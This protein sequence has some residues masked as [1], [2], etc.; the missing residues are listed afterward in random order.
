MKL[1]M[2][3]GVGD[4]EHVP[5]LLYTFVCKVPLFSLKSALFANKDALERMC[6]HF[7]NVSYI[8]GYR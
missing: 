8:P 1:D 2:D 3:M 6:P 7:L 5:P 4:R